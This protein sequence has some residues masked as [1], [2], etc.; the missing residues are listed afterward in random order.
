M[1]HRVI[2]AVLAL[3][4][5]V[6]TAG[7]GASK[8]FS[9]D[10]VA[11]AADKTE[12]AGGARVAFTAGVAGQTVNGGGYVDLRGQA[13][14][15]SLALPGSAGRIDEVMANRVLYMHFPPAVAQHLPGGKA[16]VKIDIAKVLQSKGINLGALRSSTESNP[17]DQLAQLRGAGD[18]SKVGT[19]TVRGAQTT[20]YHAVIDLRRAADKAP[21]G[22]RAAARSSVDQLIKVTGRSTI[23]MDVWI[24]GAGRLRRMRSTQRVQGQAI[25]T[26]M[27]FFDFGARQ[28]VQPPPAS[29][30][31]DLTSAVAS[32]LS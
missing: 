31:A 29:Q 9:S 28:T 2:L 6:A 16:W 21:A 8:N 7:C 32:H 10:V 23:P 17:A 15:L 12:A 13:A 4:C 20:H 30:T 26:T 27:D 1:R 3:L 11:Q 19:A 14:R 25:T 5:A 24:D 22:R 18:V